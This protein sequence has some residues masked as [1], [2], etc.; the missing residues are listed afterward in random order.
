MLHPWWEEETPPHTHTPLDSLPIVHPTV[1]TRQSPTPNRLQSSFTRH[2]HS[3]DQQRS[4]AQRSCLGSRET[5][6]VRRSHHPSSG[7][8]RPSHVGPRYVADQPTAPGRCRRGSTRSVRHLAVVAS[9][10]VR[11]S[12]SGGMNGKVDLP[13]PLSGI[14]EQDRNQAVFRV[15]ESNT[16]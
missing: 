12:A 5:K 9:T 11:T 15:F 3:L 2:V 13:P 6:D 1:A 10:R 4:T 16:P 14:V 8:P 7:V